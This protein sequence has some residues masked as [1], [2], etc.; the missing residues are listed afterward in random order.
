MI[1]CNEQNRFLLTDHLASIS[2]PVEKILLEPLP[3]NTAPAL[4]LA[5]LY[6]LRNL[7]DHILFSMPSDHF[8]EEDE[9]FFEV[10]DTAYK[11]AE[12]GE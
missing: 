9:D 3:K 6:L 12:T 10:V 11:L 8:I 4:T 1:V 2:A 5:A 7:G